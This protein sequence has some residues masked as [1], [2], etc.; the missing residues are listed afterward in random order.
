MS[1]AKDENDEALPT[2]PRIALTLGQGAP[3]SA[4]PLSLPQREDESLKLIEE[5]HATA[6][7]ARRIVSHERGEPS[8]PEEDADGDLH[9]EATR[10]LADRIG[11]ARADDR[12]FAQLLPK[13]EELGAAYEVLAEA[14]ALASE[15]EHLPESRRGSG[16]P[17]LALLAEAQAMA[18]TALG[19]LLG[20]ADPLQLAVFDWLKRRAAER[21]VFLKRFMRADD[22]PEIA[23]LVDLR[24]R[25]RRE[26]ER[27]AAARGPLD[28]TTEKRP[29]AAP[30]F[31][32]EVE[33]AAKLLMGKAVVLIGGDGR[34]EASQALETALRLR[35][36]IWI[37][38]REHQSIERFESVIARPDVVAVF[39]AIRWAS[40]SFGDVKAFCER[41]GKAFVRLPGG[42]SPNQVAEQF[43]KQASGHRRGTHGTA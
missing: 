10:R 30:H 40:H 20:P 28:R 7:A 29:K 33:A 8:S 27:L 19:P 43:L 11:W 16:E 9:R 3:P 34:P 15:S 13:V 1:E 36:L 24:E 5:C 14:L 22:R 35:E 25:L 18:R 42:Y 31:G 4:K 12:W 38:T 21:H 37:E 6:W 41:H 23:G 32:P 2:E 26:R 17:S 39:L